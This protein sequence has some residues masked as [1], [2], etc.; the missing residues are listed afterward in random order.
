MHYVY[1]SCVCIYVNTFEHF[2]SIYTL[3]LFERVN[4]E[5]VI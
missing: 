3:N 1:N 4:K 5:F 2:D